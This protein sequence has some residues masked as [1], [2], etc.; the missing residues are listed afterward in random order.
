[1]KVIN[2]TRES[3]EALGFY[4]AELTVG[5]KTSNIVFFVVDAKPRYSLLLGRDWIN[6]NMCVPST[7]HQQ[8]MFWNNGKVKVQS[9]NKK[10]FLADFK[11]I[12]AMY[13]TPE[14]QSIT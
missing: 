13:Y 12:E 6:F 5:G 2:I 9:T 14:F 11:K 3:T 4:I 10:P 8:L 7:L 1:M